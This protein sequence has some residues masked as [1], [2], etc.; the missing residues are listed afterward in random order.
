MDGVEKKKKKKK[1]A[2]SSD[3]ILPLS[4]SMLLGAAGAISSLTG[5]N[6]SKA[7]FLRT[8]QELG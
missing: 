1:K 5:V 8:Q 2:T 3:N 4:G 6:V 7:F